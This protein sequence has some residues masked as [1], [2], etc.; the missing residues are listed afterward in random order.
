MSGGGVTRPTGPI[1]VGVDGSADAGR[2]LDAAVELAQAFGT[3][4]RA[5]HALGL[6]T[7]I[8]GEHVPSFDHRNDVERLLHDRWC[9]H[10]D[11]FGIDYRIELHDG[12]PTEVLVHLAED[13]SPAFLVVGAR[14]IGENLDRDLGS[15]SYHVMRHARCP[16]VVVPAPTNH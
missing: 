12:N 1:V 3:E 16:V 6:M 5:V 14:G 7:I 10:L 11:Q 15:T 13:A 2:A 4:L 8:D 9:G